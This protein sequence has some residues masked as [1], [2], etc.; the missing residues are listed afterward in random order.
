MISVAVAS[1][2]N[3]AYQGYPKIVCLGLS[4]MAVVEKASRALHQ[5]RPLQIP[6]PGVFD[7]GQVREGERRSE[8]RRD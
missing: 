5:P 2:K 1:L 7:E 3:I 4:P 8:C 6:E